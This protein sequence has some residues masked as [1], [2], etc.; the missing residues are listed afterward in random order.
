DAGAVETQDA[1]RLLDKVLFENFARGIPR[2][3]TNSPADGGL[4]GRHGP[5]AG[6]VKQLL[7][8]G[9]GGITVP[10]VGV[11]PHDADVSLTGSDHVRQRGDP[12]SGTHAAKSG[13]R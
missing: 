4:T 9:R 11:E 7:R 1:A 3:L 2:G 12:L 6:P 5:A 10:R 8:E 13:G